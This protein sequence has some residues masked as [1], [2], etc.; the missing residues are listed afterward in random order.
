MRA[1]CF[2]AVARL[3]GA[4]CSISHNR[5][6][7]VPYADLHTHTHCSDG[8]RSPTSLVQ[9]AAE[10]GLHVLSVTDHDTVAGLS[11][12]QQAAESCGVTLVPGVEMSV[13]VDGDEIHLLGYG[14]DPTHP[15]L[16]DQLS[17]LEAARADRMQAMLERL[18]DQGISI[19]EEAVQAE[20]RNAESLGRPHLAAALVEGGHVETQQEAFDRYLG[21]D[22]PAFVA[23]PPVPAGGVIEMLHDAGGLAVLAHPGHWTPSARL[24]ALAER[25]LDGIETVHPSHD[26]S[27]ERYYERWAQAKD[28]ICTGGSDYHG[29]REGEDDLFGTRGLDRA[30]W[31]RLRTVFDERT[32]WGRRPVEGSNPSLRS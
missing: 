2:G 30:A 14:F 19:A 7:V 16:L 9:A 32:A 13:T 24:R 27:L 5:L 20:A 22:G 8:H 10:R 3:G 18:R 11:E 17:A 21:R 31:R 6:F 15:A 25:G 28:L 4:L 26:A 12:A 29:H 23:K 1:T